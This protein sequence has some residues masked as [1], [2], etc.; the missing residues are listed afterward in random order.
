MAYFLAYFSSYFP[1]PAFTFFYFNRREKYMLYLSFLLLFTS[2][3]LQS[4][5][6]I[7]CKV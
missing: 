3:L 2:C 4:V 6:E 1:F 7:G 5:G